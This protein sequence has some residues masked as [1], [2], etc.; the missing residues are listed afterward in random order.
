MSAKP[1]VRHI[2]PTSTSKKKKTRRHLNATRVTHLEEYRHGS[3]FTRAASAYLRTYLPT[4]WDTYFTS[5]R[6]GGYYGL[7]L[8]CPICKITP[9]SELKYGHRRWRWLCVHMSEHT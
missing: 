5:Q 4:G 8:I 6:A 3:K 1:Q 2:I 7:S 9:P